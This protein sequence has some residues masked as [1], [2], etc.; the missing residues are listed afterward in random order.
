MSTKLLPFNLKIMELTPERTARLK[1][2]TS[3]DIM[4]GGTKNFH[5]NG[6]FSTSIFGRF[7]DERRDHQ[8]S[9]VDLKT[10]ILHPLIYDTFCKLKGFYRGIMAGREYAV[11]DAELKDFVQSDMMHGETGYGFFLQHCF[12]IVFE[13]RDSIQRKNNIELIRKYGSIAKT[14]KVLVI[15]AGLRDIDVGEDGRTKQHEINDYYR[16]IVAVANLNARTADP[17]DPAINQSRASL[18]GSFNSVYDTLQ[19]IVSGKRGFI[20][21]KYASRRVFNGTQN[22]ITAMDPS[23]HDM[24]APNALSLN[25]TVVGL[26]QMAKAIEP[27]TISFLK[28]SILSRIFGG[29]N[30]AILIDRKTL[31]PE[32]VSLTSKTIDQWTSIEGLGR[33]IESYRETTTRH[34]P[35]IVD[36]HYLALAYTGPDGTFR[37]FND[38]DELPK[39]RSRKDVHPVSLAELLYTAG[40][41]EWNN[42]PAFVTRYPITGIGSIYPSLVYT[43][44]T[45]VGETRKELGEDWQPIGEDYVAYEYPSQSK[46]ELF[47]AMCAN[48]SRLEGLGAD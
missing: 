47:D 26:F 25:H 33:V 27:K 28:R 45:V 36:D 40:Y 5:E 48:L 38:I 37:I 39:D 19:G 13:Q 7:G 22:V 43:K 30:K 12:D 17:T 23:S 8:F 2:V 15:P 18:Q 46:P 29:G 44:V 1:P 24:E 34:K 9:F 20:Q 21:N 11:W 3:L 6:L 31:K 14:D 16:R 10:Q 42:Y 32:Y 41:R 35:I 4:E